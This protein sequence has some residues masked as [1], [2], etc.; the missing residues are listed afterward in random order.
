MPAHKNSFFVIP[1]RLVHARARLTCIR[2]RQL[3]AWPKA[4]SGQLEHH[5]LQ[6]AGCRATG[7]GLPIRLSGAAPV[8]LS[9]QDVNCTATGHLSSRWLFLHRARVRRHICASRPGPSPWP[10]P[11]P[12]LALKRSMRRL[13]PATSWRG[14]VGRLVLCRTFVTNLQ[15]QQYTNTV[16]LVSIIRTLL[17]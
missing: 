6:Q 14:R 8:S 12:V 15:V 9:W 16:T 2:P 5:W 17:A 13:G 4:S 10:A 1:A 7:P 11:P 3:D